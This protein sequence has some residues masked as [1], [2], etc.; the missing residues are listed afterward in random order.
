[1]LLV[2]MQK[3]LRFYSLA[4]RNAQGQVLLGQENQRRVLPVGRHP[5]FCHFLFHGAIVGFG[6]SMSEAVLT[7]WLAV[8]RGAHLS[9]AVCVVIQDI[10][11]TLANLFQPRIVGAVRTKPLS[12]LGK[13]RVW[14]QLRSV[15]SGGTLPEKLWRTPTH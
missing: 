4:Y 9:H 15:R 12:R 8:L 13:L 7:T 2:V 6:F 14:Y 10:R 5:C 1:M 11:E 3:K